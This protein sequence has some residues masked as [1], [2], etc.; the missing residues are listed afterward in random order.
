MVSETAFV[1]MDS[2]VNIDTWICLSATIDT[3]AV[4]LFLLS[5]KPDKVFGGSLSNVT[6]L[7]S[8][9]LHFSL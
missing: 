5:P 4:A 1:D 2:S 8:L 6:T 9:S 3:T 7:L